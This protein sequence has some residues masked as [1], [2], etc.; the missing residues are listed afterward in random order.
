MGFLDF[1]L[2][3]IDWG[4]LASLHFSIIGLIRTIFICEAFYLL[5]IDNSMYLQLLSTTT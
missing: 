4:S 2:M 5:R 3:M 1:E